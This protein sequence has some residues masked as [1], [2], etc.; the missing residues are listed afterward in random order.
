MHIEQTTVR[1]L[2]ITGVTNL[3]PVTVFLE[4]FEPGKG[5]IVIECWGKSWAASWGA[6]GKDST[7]SEF[8]CQCHTGYLI[9]N[10][11][12][13]I[14]SEITDNE[15]I[16]DGARKKI[17]RMRRDGDLKKDQARDLWDECANYSSVEAISH[18]KDVTTIFGDEWWYGLPTRPNPEYTYLVKIVQAVQ[19]AIET[20]LTAKL[21][22]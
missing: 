19:A 7:I 10:L 4:D 13:D 21:A 1:K 5:K 11:A 6:M 8:F 12:V 18:W 20:T 17:L 9:K 3:D 22:A 16:T 15:A 14:N 2:R